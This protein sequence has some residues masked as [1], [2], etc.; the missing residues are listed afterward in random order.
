VDLNTRIIESA[1]NGRQELLRDLHNHLHQ[2]R[3]KYLQ[4]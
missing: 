4:I 1:R 2:Y 3:I